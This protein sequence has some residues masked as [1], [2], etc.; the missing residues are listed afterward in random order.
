MKKLPLVF[1]GFVFST[2]LLLAMPGVALADNDQPHVGIDF[3]FGVPVYEQ[4][5]YVYV[6]QR[7]VYIY[8]PRE[9]YQRSYDYQDNRGYEGDHRRWRGHRDE[10]QHHDENDD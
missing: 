8:Q 10:H 5:A 1:A 2:G 7:P 9:Y 3:S 4:P 6:P